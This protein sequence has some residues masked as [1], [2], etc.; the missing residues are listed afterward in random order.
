MMEDRKQS[1]EIYELNPP[2][3]DLP[4][5]GIDGR[6][7]AGKRFAFRPALGSIGSGLKFAGSVL[8][9]LCLPGSCAGCQRID[10]QPQRSWCLG[11]WKKIPWV[12]SPLCPGCGTPFTDSPDSA[13]HLCGE[14]IEPTFHFDTAR[15]AVLH[16]GIIRTRIHQFKFGAQ[17][18]WTPPLVELLEI[19]YA[20][21][22]LPAPG[23]IVPVPLHPKRLK[24]RGFNQSALLA[25]ELAR[26]IKVPVSF[27]II[28]RKNQTQPQTRLKRGER[29]KNVKGA[30]EIADKKRVLGRR[31]LLVDDVFTTG[32]TL[33]ECARTLKRKGGASEVHAIT[34][35][36]ALPG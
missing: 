23:L 27:D 14:C 33:S 2:E 31:I 24:E 13:D 1:P 29:L 25:G 28:V 7:S 20:G 15:S 10:T 9:D 36:R 22:G 6:A 32:T 4:S 5:P 16:K 17:M 11:C 12:K 3:T 34:V 35:T 18:E 30:F 8:L 19:A 21:W 26:K